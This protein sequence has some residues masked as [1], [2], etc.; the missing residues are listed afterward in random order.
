MAAWWIR[1]DHGT[2]ACEYA[3][4]SP[5]VLPCEILRLVLSLARISAPFSR[6]Q[7]TQLM[8]TLEILKKVEAAPSALPAAVQERREGLQELHQAA[9]S[10]VQEAQELVALLE[11]VGLVL[12]R[13]RVVQVVGH[14]A[15]ESSKVL[16]ELVLREKAGGT[17]LASEAEK[18]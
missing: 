16:E 12:E 4:R 10:K 15:G 9:T 5:R 14:P 1:R 18:G 13:K 6:G 17:S 7:H 8:A 11:R 3:P 2:L